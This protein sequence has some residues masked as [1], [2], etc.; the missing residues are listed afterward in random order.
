MERMNEDLPYEQQMMP[1]LAN[2]DK[3]M[4]ENKFLREQLK[5]LNE[6]KKLAKT[7]GEVKSIINR[8]EKQKEK[9]EWIQKTLRDYLV[10]LGIK[11]P[12]FRTVTSL[13][14]TVVSITP[15]GVID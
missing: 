1:I 11:L 14:K 10:G 13:V 2:Y 4:S 9:E 6:Y 12:M 3:L 7:P 5:E 15:Q 8:I